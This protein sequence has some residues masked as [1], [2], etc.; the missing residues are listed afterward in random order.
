MKRDFTETALRFAKPEWTV[1]QMHDLRGLLA[2]AYVMGL[3]DAA[4]T[5]ES[6][7]DQSCGGSGTGGEGYRNLARSI[8]GLAA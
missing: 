6:W 3:S 2:Q 5:A 1:A 8:L 7:A 4:R